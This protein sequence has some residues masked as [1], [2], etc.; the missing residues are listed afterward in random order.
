GVRLHAR[1]GWLHARLLRHRGLGRLRRFRN[2]DLL[3]CN[4][5]FLILR[6]LR[7]ARRIR[8]GEG[9]CTDRGE[10][11]VRNQHL[12]SSVSVRTHVTVALGARAT[13]RAWRSAASTKAVSGSDR[14]R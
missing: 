4:R 11:A 7:S 10:Y 8:R 13:Y 6:I 3:L 2:P 14:G 1:L 5:R 12:V 9:E